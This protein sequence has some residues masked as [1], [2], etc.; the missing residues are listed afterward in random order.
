MMTFSY[1]STFV[2]VYLRQ[3]MGVFIAAVTN[4]HTQ[5]TAKGFLI[6]LPDRLDLDHSP[7]IVHRYSGFII[8]AQEYS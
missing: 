1:C 6:W 3:F 4:T 5:T 7:C 2:F 8:V